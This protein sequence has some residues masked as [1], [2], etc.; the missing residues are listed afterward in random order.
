MLEDL[1]LAIDVN[2]VTST[3]LNE[4]TYTTVKLK[5]ETKSLLGEQP[6][7]DAR[8]CLLLTLKCYQNWQLQWIQVYLVNW[9]QTII[10]LL[11]WQI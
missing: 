2:S 1:C 9:H 8:L 3:T 4:F 6:V 5:L 10:D 7:D 11:W